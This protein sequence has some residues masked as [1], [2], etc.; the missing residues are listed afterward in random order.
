MSTPTEKQ[1][2]IGQQGLTE[3]ETDFAKKPLSDKIGSSL[4]RIYDDV[5]SEPIPDEF[6]ALLEQADKKGK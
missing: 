5:V 6:L 3:G 2:Q 4:K 1:G